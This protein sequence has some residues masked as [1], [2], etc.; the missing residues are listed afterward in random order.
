MKTRIVKNNTKD[1]T[2]NEGSNRLKHR[3][4]FIKNY[5]ESVESWG[6]EIDKILNLDD[7]VLSFA[8]DKYLRLS[9]QLLEKE[10]SQIIAATDARRLNYFVEKIDIKKFEKRKK[11]YEKLLIYELELMNNY[12]KKF[13]AEL[14]EIVTIPYQKIDDDYRDHSDISENVNVI[15]LHIQF[16]VTT[17][18]SNTLDK[19][20]DRFNYDYDKSIDVLK[21]EIKGDCDSRFEFLF[22]LIK[23][24]KNGNALAKEKEKLYKQ[25][26]Q[27]KNLDKE[28]EIKYQKVAGLIKT[29]ELYFQ[30]I[31]GAQKKACEI[32]NVNE[33]SFSAWLNRKN[34]EEKRANHKKFLGW[35]GDVS[36]TD[37][38]NYKI[39][40]NRYLNNS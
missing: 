10:S 23:V 8:S 24:L 39:E 35:V 4:E 12:F 13:I 36:P 7:E 29:F 15:L 6:H 28:K 25:F 26:R 18:R 9:S 1:K 22:L 33:F 31:A 5:I 17:T 20:L 30:K 40:I 38:N 14:D 3:D 32:A 21:E 27:G 19:M 11:L 37:F 34:N 16:L 2:E